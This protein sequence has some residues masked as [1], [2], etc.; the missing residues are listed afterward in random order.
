MPFNNNIAIYRNQ[1]LI[2]KGWMQNNFFFIKSKI[3]SLLEAELM[4]KKLKNSHL[5]EAYL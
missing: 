3:Y 4:N 1:S 2:C 5:N